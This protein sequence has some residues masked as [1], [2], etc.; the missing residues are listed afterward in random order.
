MKEKKLR[1][2]LVSG[3]HGKDEGM[4]K[5]HSDAVNVM[6]MKLSALKL[7]LSQSSMLDVV[8]DGLLGKLII[9][10]CALKQ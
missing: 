3:F 8:M 6:L 10:H 9:I 5:N 7:N 2:Y 4:E 1:R